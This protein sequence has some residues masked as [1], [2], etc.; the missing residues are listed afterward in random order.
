MELAKLQRGRAED[1]CVCR[2]QGRAGGCGDK[3]NT[4]L[5]E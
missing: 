5:I 2:E 3:S 1:A 4:C